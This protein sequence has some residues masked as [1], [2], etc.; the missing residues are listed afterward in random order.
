MTNAAGDAPRIR[1]K[2]PHVTSMCRAL[3]THVQGCFRFASTRGWQHHEESQEAKQFLNL[4]DSIGRETLVYVN[5]LTRGCAECAKCAA[6]MHFAETAGSVLRRV[7][8]ESKDKDPPAAAKIFRGIC[9]VRR[10]GDGTLFAP[11]HSTQKTRETAEE[12][13]WLRTR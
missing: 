13:F 10:K 5:T 4:V 8:V 12:S 11:I 2:A 3:A 7:L 1:R 9:K 6:R